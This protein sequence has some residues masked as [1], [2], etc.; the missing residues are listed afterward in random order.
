MNV[1]AI[2]STSCSLTYVDVRTSMKC[3]QPRCSWF[4]EQTTH[5]LPPTERFSIE[6]RHAE[7]SGQVLPYS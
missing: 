2:I 5:D 4:A 3:A 1:C 6:F 7:C